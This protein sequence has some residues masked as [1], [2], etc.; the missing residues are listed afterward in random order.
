MVMSFCN[1]SLPEFNIL[2]SKRRRLGNSNQNQWIISDCR[3]F[4][5]IFKKKSKS[6]NSNVN[7]KKRAEKEYGVLLI[8]NHHSKKASTLG[9]SY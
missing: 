5:E 6:F 9:A 3:R 4:S 8:V 2:M 7:N 1:F